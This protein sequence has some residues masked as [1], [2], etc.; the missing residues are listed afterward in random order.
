MVDNYFNQTLTWE[1]VAS[2]NKYNEPA[3]TSTS[4]KGRKETGNKL[5]RNAQ[6]QEVVSSAMVF[7]K[8]AIQ[9]NDLID[10]KKVI[11]VEDMNMLDGDV[12]FYEVNLL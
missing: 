8:S 4:I 7:T 11:S 12:M 10:G 9:N 2:T 6:G 3:Y 1:T 5:V